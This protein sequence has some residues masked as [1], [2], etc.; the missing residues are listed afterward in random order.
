[1]GA[2]NAI[3]SALA[4][5]SGFTEKPKNRS[6]MSS[7]DGFTTFQF[8]SGKA[9]SSHGYVYG[10]LMKRFPSNV[11][12]C[13]K[14]MKITKDEKSA[15]F[16]VPDEHLETFQNAVKEISGFEWLQVC[17]TLPEF[18][19]M[20]VRRETYQGSGGGFLGGGKGG[21]SGGFSNGRGSSGRGGSGRDFRGGR[22]PSGGRTGRGGSFGSGRGSTSEKRKR[23]Y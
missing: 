5:I 22:G 12:Q 21:N 19:K 4:R 17:E 16:D 9:I 18:Q 13:P 3:C 23:E 15:A 8:N 11:A 7:A 14:G 1:M 2:E 6:L 20:D 10:A